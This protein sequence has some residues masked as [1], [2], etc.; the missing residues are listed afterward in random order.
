M[1]SNIFCGPLLHG[2][3]CLSP[4]GGTPYTR[5]RGC[6]D[7]MGGFF[8]EE[9]YVDGYVLESVPMGLTEIIKNRLETVN[10]HRESRNLNRF[11][12]IS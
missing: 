1:R 2:F 5:I 6:A 12:L 10:Y 3:V 7:Y 11:L 9:K 8:L 4:E